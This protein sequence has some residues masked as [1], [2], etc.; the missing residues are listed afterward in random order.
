MTKGVLFGLLEYRLIATMRTK[1]FVEHY[2]YKRLEDVSE[3]FEKLFE[4]V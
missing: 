3:A 4:T 1:F 2:D